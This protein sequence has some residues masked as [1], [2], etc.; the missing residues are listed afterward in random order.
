MRSTRLLFTLLVLCLALVVVKADVYINSPRGSNNRLDE[1]NRDRDN[2][3]RLFDSQVT[4]REGWLGVCRSGAPCMIP[5]A[6]VSCDG[7][8]L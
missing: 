2:G 5:I 6:S 4:R 3:D 8:R 1:A 7:R